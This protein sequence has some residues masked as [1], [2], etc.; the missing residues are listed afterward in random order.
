M[1]LILRIYIQEFRLQHVMFKIDW[2]II[3]RQETVFLN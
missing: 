2:S 1:I 3:A